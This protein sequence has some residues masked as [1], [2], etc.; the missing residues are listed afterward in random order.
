[1]SETVKYKFKWRSFTSLYITISFLVM[2]VSGAILYIAPP[3][4][5]VH[6]THIS[7]LG[8]EK[9]QWQ[10]LHIIFTFLFV[11]ASA[12]HLYFNWS[13]FISYLKDKLNKRYRLRRE[14]FFSLVLTSGIF[15]LI[16]WD[17]PP[18]RDVIDFGE[19]MKSS[20]SSEAAEPPVPHAEEM[21]FTTAG[22][23]LY[24]GTMQIG[25]K[26]KIITITR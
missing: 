24:F 26:S 20:W 1:M 3:G 8:F 17:V 13:V 12:F 6:W 23:G 11:I 10:A 4:R 22:N 19:S 2:I 5:I 21:T 18:F 15:I 16:L 14:L 9:H 7:I 25:E